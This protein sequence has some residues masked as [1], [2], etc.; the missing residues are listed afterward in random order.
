[1]GKLAQNLQPD[2]D[3][4]IVGAGLSGIGTACHLTQKC[5]N[6]TYMVL[7]RR[8]NIGGTWDLFRYPGIRSDSD[9]STFGFN[10]RP[11]TKN[12]VLA[13][14][15]EIRDYLKDTADEYGVT[16]K[17]NF[18]CKVT[19]VKWSSKTQ[20]WTIHYVNEKS[21]APNSA[22]AR[23]VIGC[24]G[25]YDY[26][27][28]YTPEFKGSKD[29]EG[30]IVHPQFWPENLDYA[31]KKVVVIGSGATAV[32]L[33]PAMADK[34]KKIT[35]LQRSPSYIYAVP[36]KD[37][38][39][40]FLRGKVSDK[41]IYRMTRV[42]NVALQRSVFALSKKY[43][44]T[45]KKIFKGDVKKRL[46]GSSDMKHFSPS[47]N[48]WDQR[49]CA[50]PDGDLFKVIK[51]GK[52]DIVT[53]HIEHF[54][55]T[56]IQLTSG[57]HIEADIIITATG[58]KLQMGGGSTFYMDEKPVNLN[59]RLTYKGVMI[60][61]VPNAAVI[62][63]YN[64]GS[65]T[66]KS[67]IS[68]EYICRLMNY[69]D[70]KGLIEVVAN[71]DE[72]EMSENLTVFGEMSSGYIKRAANV[73]PKQGSDLPWK[74]THNYAIDMP[75]LRFSKIKDEYISFKKAHKKKGFIRKALK[76]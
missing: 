58:L 56:G 41:N 12:S 15:D 20:M 13:Q 54:T 66:L 26:D 4:I 22:T 9:M 29:F 1:M 75:M 61:G 32:T 69:M 49:I 10:F 17:I 62:F 40:E 43:P 21:G 63:G 30:T 67:D 46:A 59:D 45:M 36:S 52:A 8:E 53:D 65:W 60:D 71:G 55:K 3:V 16:P 14:G 25:Y 57:E 50:V 6:K 51:S 31:D 18:S 48:P 39:A 37:H 11:W 2:Y 38:V 24:T 44:D 47:Y 23:F 68:S 64:N 5:P 73:L 76:I 74:V 72:A 33:I 70:K 19:A 7:E 27:E 28:G 35:M 42:R 34:V